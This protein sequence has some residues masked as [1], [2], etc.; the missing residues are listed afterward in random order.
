MIS[1][2]Q[3]VINVCARI[4]PGDKLYIYEIED[5]ARI[6]LK[7]NAYPGRTMQETIQRRF[8]EVASLCEMDYDGK[9]YVK[10]I[11][12]PPLTEAEKEAKQQNLFA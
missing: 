7:R 1:I 4:R 3:A 8:R 12:L 2:R 9:Q 5:R 6:E 11:P 10:L